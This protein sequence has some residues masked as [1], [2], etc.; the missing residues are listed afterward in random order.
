MYHNLKGTATMALFGVDSMAAWAGGQRRS[1]LEG[2]LVSMTELILQFEIR[3]LH[4]FSG[5]HLNFICLVIILKHV[6]KKVSLAWLWRV[7]VRR[8]LKVAVDSHH[9][10]KLL[11][12]LLWVQF[13]SW[14]SWGFFSWI[15]WIAYTLK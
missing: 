11:F 5:F 14:C 9:R 10:S 2:K 4:Y 1:H 12:L 15:L 8:G 7:G 6:V 13:R 3:C